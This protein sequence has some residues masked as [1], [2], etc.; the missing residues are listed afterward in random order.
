MKQSVARSRLG[1]PRLDE[2]GHYHFQFQF[3]L[4]ESVFAGH[5][6]GRP[7]LP[8]VFQ[9]E[10]TRQ[11]AE[12]VAVAASAG[13]AGDSGADLTVTRIV[14]AKFSRVI[15]PGE[16]IDLLLRCVSTGGRVVARSNLSIGDERAGECR[17]ELVE[18][19]DA[20]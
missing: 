3:A 8:G 18:R 13:P 2:E 14:K 19:S 1:P 10:M 11:A 20:V 7:I 6:P 4:E 16:V 12:A 5:F 15:E 9:I 17:L